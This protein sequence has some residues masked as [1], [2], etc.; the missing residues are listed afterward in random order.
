MNASLDYCRNLY[1]L[2]PRKTTVA[3]VLLCAALAYG[4]YL[5]NSF[6][7]DDMPYLLYNPHVHDP[8]FPGLIWD[9]WATRLL[10]F[11]TLALEWPLWRNN[12]A[13]YHFV[14]LLL[15]CANAFLA[16]RLIAL[17][18][19]ACGEKENAEPA[20][21]LGAL[22]FLLHP[23]QTEALNLV[24]QRSAL[25][26]AFFFLSCAVCYIKNILDG[27]R[28]YYF[29]AL[30]AA[31]LSQFCK[32]NAV[33]LPLVLCA[34][35]LATGHRRKTVLRLLPFFACALVAP[36]LDFYTRQSTLLDLQLRL[37]E[38]VSGLHYFY[39]QLYAQLL[40]AQ[41]LVFPIGL[42]IDHALPVLQVFFNTRTLAGVAFLA[43]AAL[44]WRRYFKDNRPLLF[45]ALFYACTMLVESSFL[46]LRDTAVE[47]RLYLPCAGA[48]LAFAVGAL[49]AARHF[50]RRALPC[51]A[52]VL[53]C[54]CALTHVRNRDWR[55]EIVVWSDAIA[56]QPTAERPYL[57]R[58][59]ALEKAHHY[60]AALAD[61]DRALL[62]LSNKKEDYYE[63]KPIIL[64]NEQQLRV[65][66]EAFRRR[67]YLSANKSQ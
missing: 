39:T 5:G 61:Y 30:S 13:G 42:N 45:A 19:R 63:I 12:P 24:V 48:A 26:C 3:L 14:A 40:Y 17:V 66:I 46:P 33:T 43:V 22:A 6:H 62:L 21:L 50:G 36:A 38:P 16:G 11:W 57:Y 25:L 10:P 28:I 51:A 34:A 65:A 20:A 1:I 32:E 31:A 52:G 7:Y 2:H 47:Y 67:Q 64:H 55:D 23:V 27:G 18:L 44:A 8:R 9:F 58:G 56:K 59:A 35:H 60:E 49:A 54:W 41:L 53:V 29:I 15:H 4:G 37:A